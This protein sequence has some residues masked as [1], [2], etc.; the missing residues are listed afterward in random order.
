[1]YLHFKSVR[2]HVWTTELH[3][4][5]VIQNS[6]TNMNNLKFKDKTKFHIKLMDENNIYHLFI[7]FKLN[8]ER[9]WNRTKVSIVLHVYMSLTPFPLFL[10]FFWNLALLFQ[11][12]FVLLFLFLIKWTFNYYYFYHYHSLLLILW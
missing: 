5:I 12:L 8:Q 2:I 4:W 3:V 6:E 11:H 1:M 10:F 9:K 7:Y